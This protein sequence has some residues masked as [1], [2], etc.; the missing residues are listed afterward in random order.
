MKILKKAIPILLLFL[1][2][3]VF[4]QPV[5]L[6]AQFNG[7]FDYTAFGNTLNIQ[8]NGGGGPCNIL[9]ESDADLT[10]LP[11]QTFIA[12]VM[13]WSGS[14]TGDFDVK[15]NGTDVTAERTFSEVFNSLNY[16][17]AYADV[18]SIVNADGNGTYT[19]SELDL[20]GVI[21][22]YC[23]GG[24]NYGGWTVIVIYQEDTLPLNQISLFD[25]FEAVWAGNN[26]LTIVLDNIDVLS[27]ELAKIGFLAWEGDSSIA[28]DESLRINGNLIS[29]PPLNPANNAFN[30]TNSFTNSSDLY[31][32]DLDFYDI[33]NVINPGDTS[34]QID[35]TSGQDLVIINN[36]ITII[37]SEVPD[38]TIAIDN[39][40]VI[41][42]INDID[43]D[44]TVFNLN[45]TAILPGLTPVAFY[46]NDVLVG[47]A[48]TV[49]DIP[50]GGSESGSITLT[51]PGG[52]PNPFTLKAVV[53]DDGTGVGIVNETDEDNNEVEVEVINV[54]IDVDLGADIDICTGTDVLLDADQ[55]DPLITYQWFLNA[56]AIA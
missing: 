50:I 54:P 3:L 47:Q 48:Q 23:S 14:G 8:E 44:Y 31:N 27:D 56:V 33:E 12:A 21:G 18:T 34:V 28:L 25:G 11:G 43:V 5:E 9:T 26:T 20:T 4:S 39:V 16:F 19:L 53:D 38:A 49:A 29:N 37:N 7:Q 10:L 6:F 15:L 36:V 40:E 2:I 41:C 51:I 13:Y 32:M 22:S 17:S 1:P 35:L 42:G 52:T 30:G 24:T 55:A 45:S 46:I